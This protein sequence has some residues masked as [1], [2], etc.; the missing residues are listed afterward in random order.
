VALLAA[1]ASPSTD[2]VVEHQGAQLSRA[3]LLFHLP[4]GTTG[5]DSA[6]LAAAYI[7]EWKRDISFQR[8]LA[9]SHPQLQQRHSLLVAD[10]SRKLAQHLVLEAVADARVD[11]LITPQQLAEYY[12]QQKGQFLA[13]SLQLQVLHLAAERSQLD[14]PG[15]PT[16][17][18]V[19]RALVGPRSEL[20][21]KIR[22]LVQ[23]L[24]SSW[25]TPADLGRYQAPHGVNLLAAPGR[26]VLVYP[27]IQKPRERVHFFYIAGLVNPGEPLPLATVAGVLRRA[28]LVQRRQA[29]IAAYQQQVG[30]PS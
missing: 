19:Q 1:C 11:T 16:S 13:Q 22:A 3:E 18:D 20:A 5:E 6:R 14:A 15:L 2:A 8:L 23:G 25:V 17:F 26:A 10:Y 12:A 4:P 29:F 30:P 9:D 7:A 27:D 21:S 24:D 28:L